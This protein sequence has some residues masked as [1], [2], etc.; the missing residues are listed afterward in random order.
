MKLLVTGRVGQVARALFEAGAMA[1]ETVAVVGRPALDLLD[2]SS[3]EAVIDRERPTIVI[4]AAAYT[5]VDQAESDEAAAFAVNADGA[6]H[7][8]EACAA[9]ALPVIHLSTDYVFD[10]KKDIAYRESDPTGPINVYGRSKLAGEEAVAAA[11]A[12]HLIVRTSWVY[13][14][15]GSNFVLTMLRLAQTRRIINVVS[16]QF[17]CPTYAP[18]LAD[19]LLSMARRATSQPK[20]TTWGV[21]HAAGCGETNWCEFARD[22]YRAASAHGLPAAEVQPIQGKDYPTPAARPQNSRLNTQALHQHFGAKLPDWRE[23]TAACVARIVRDQPVSKVR[24]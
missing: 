11:C 12:H 24:S 16:D 4:N 19:A 3:I 17:G 6:R 13:S 15:W 5:Q 1:G 7:V 18:H 10:G 21:Y 20:T 23:G 2:R 22:I 9:R 8:A 14:P